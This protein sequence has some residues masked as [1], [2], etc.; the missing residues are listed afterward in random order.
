[1]LHCIREGYNVLFTPLLLVDT[2]SYFA[3]SD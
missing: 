3:D 1:M 2:F